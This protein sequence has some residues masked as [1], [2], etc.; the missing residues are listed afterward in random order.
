MIFGN[1]RN[2]LM[3]SCAIMCATVST[4]ALAQSKNF[5]IPAQSAQS[6]VTAFARQA[7]VQ[8]IAAR[9]DTK[10]KRTN[11]VRGTMTVERALDTLLEGTGLVARR[12]GAQTFTVVT[13][14]TVRTQ[15]GNLSRT[16]GSVDAN[17]DES[18][19][20]VVTG[21]HIRQGQTTSPVVTA[22]REEIEKAGHSNLGDYIRDVPQNFTGGQNPGVLGGGS[23]GGS[24]NLASTST[25]N[26][27][28]L[29][30]DATLTLING[31]RVAYDGALQGIDISAIPLAALDR[32]EIVADGASALYGSDAVGGVANVILRRE[33]EGLWTSAR[34]GGTTAGGN[35]QQQY[36]AVTGAKWDGG[37]FMIAGDFNRSTA[38][39][40]DQRSFTRSRDPSTTLL[41]AQQQYSGVV[42]GHQ[43][44]TEQIQ[45][46][47]DGQYSRRTSHASS[48]LTVD[49]PATT[50][51]YLIDPRVESYAFTPS[52]EFSMENGWQ[53]DLGGTYSR[54]ITDVTTQ[55][56]SAAALASVTHVN[57][58]NRLRSVDLRG[59]GP[60]AHLPGGDLELAVGAGYRHFSLDGQSQRR[61]TSTTTRLLN[62]DHNEKVFYTYG[63]LAIPIV[64][65]ENRQSFIESLQLSAAV[66]Y[67]RY[68]GLASVA[69]PKLGLIYRPTT[70][71]VIKGGWGKSFKAPTFYQRYRVYQALLLRASTFGVTGANANLPVLYLAGGNP[72]LQP[73]RANTWNISVAVEPAPSLRIEANYFNV[74]YKNRVVDPITSILGALDNPIY[75]DLIVRNPS[76]ELQAALIAP[77][78]SAL[79][80]QNVTG[81]PYDPATV[82]AVVDA[83]SQ[84]TAYQNI[85]GVDLNLKY[86]LSI[87]SEGN[88]DFT[89]AA[90]YI[91]SDRRLLADQATTPD[92]GVIFR[93][94]HWRGRGGATFE[95]NNISISGFVQY[96]GGVLDNRL[97]PD[98][99]VGSFVSVDLT[100]RISG[101][102][103]SRIFRG[104]DLTVSLANLFNEKPDII[105]SRSANDPTYDSTNYSGL[106][107]SI[108]L[109]L[110]KRW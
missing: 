25:L 47:F 18:A 23:Q 14:G 6:G 43:T 48:P 29:G 78:A 79:G 82:Y 12:T 103:S 32:I 22:R 54:S 51:G 110:A 87:G 40:A 83:R 100:A 41:P 72:D 88:L 106:G 101:S 99:R 70:N 9:R 92:A 16:T 91:H 68:D 74:R 1:G 38:V 45:F 89:A 60:L 15:T 86:G 21:T 13:A 56:F 30:P 33:Y 10:D 97:S 7:D 53:I 42:S 62:I 34:I 67:E 28:G 49:A 27:R 57:Y 5:D 80:L 75:S 2:A 52:V 19:E 102:E 63:E 104:V 35:F 3:A 105:R 17:A 66:R 46:K 58:D 96:T 76:P 24:D 108:S 8:I 39:M 61:S 44:I 77:A 4:P 98:V 84:N 11:A 55:T 94:P 69:S 31:H 95:Q 73:E 37:A 93:P 59:S 65:P 107:R 64:G 26:L 36:N 81:A 90:S 50:S 20:I 109:T 85:Q 71:I